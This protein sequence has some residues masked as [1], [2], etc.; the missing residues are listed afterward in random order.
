MIPGRQTIPMYNIRTS[1]YLILHAGVGDTEEPFHRE[2]YDTVQAA[3]EGDA[4]GWQEDGEE[5]GEYPDLVVL[6][7]DWE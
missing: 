3:G 2:G 7:E 6:A 4:G 5:V 1:W